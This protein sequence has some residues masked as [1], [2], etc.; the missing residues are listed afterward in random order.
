MDRCRTFDDYVSMAA[1]AFVDGLSFAHSSSRSHADDVID[2]TAD[3][4]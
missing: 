4:K 2:E 1:V 3:S